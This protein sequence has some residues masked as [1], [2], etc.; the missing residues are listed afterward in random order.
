MKGQKCQRIIDFIIILVMMATVMILCQPIGRDWTEEE[1][2]RYIGAEG[3]YSADVDSYYY[4]RKAKEFSEGGIGSIKLITYRAEDKMCTSGEAISKEANGAMPMLL[5]ASAAL[6]WYGFRA[7]GINIGIYTLTIRFCSFLLSLFVIPVYLFLRRRTSRIA[8]VLGS[9][10]VTL[11]VPFFRH[12][13]AGFF[14]TDAM[15]G[16]LA[17]V[18][19]LSLF[20]C[21]VRKTRREQVIYGIVALLALVLLRFTWTAFFIY[22]VIA[23]GTAVMG[24]VG[25]RLCGKC[26]EKQKKSLAVPGAFWGAVI[27]I[28]LIL[29]WNSF[30]SLAKGFVSPSGAGD[31]PSETLNISELSKVPVSDAGSLWYHFVGVGRDITSVTGGIFALSLLLISAVICVVQLIRLIR[32]HSGENKDV[33]LL[34]ALLTWLAG[35]TVLAFFGARYMEFFTLPS[36]VIIGLK[37]D[38]IG[39]FCKERTPEGRKILYVLAGFMLFAA[40]VLRF[41]VAAVIAAVVVFVTGW[42]LARF[43]N[44]SVPAAVL[45]AAVLLPIGISCTVVC[46]QEKPYI[47]RPIEEAMTWVEKNTARDSVLADFW[48]LGYIYQY[49]GERRTLADGG[50]YNGQFF[51]WLAYMLTTEDPKLSVGIAGMLQNC[52][53]DGSEYAQELTGNAADARKL[54]KTVLPLSRSEA[55][56]ELKEK[57]AFSEAQ[58]TRLLDYTHP[59]ECPDI[60]FAVSRD[61]LAHISSLMV[62]KDWETG[63]TETA[64]ETYISTESVS[65]PNE[66]ETV[67]CTLAQGSDLSLQAV[68]ELKASEEGLT[69]RLVLPSGGR[70]DCG[71][72]L[73]IR[74]G[75]TVYD[76][77]V[78]SS[79]G[80]EQAEDEALMILEEGGKV[81]VIL[82]EKRAADSTFIKL[83]IGNGQNQDLFEKVY[84][85]AE[86]KGIQKRLGDNSSIA[87]W[88]VVTK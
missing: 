78:V 85:S 32:N 53:I 64:E 15:I 35:T 30:V 6:V 82:L 22:G 73:Y 2:E 10:L 63:D 72:L 50:T 4:L 81:S 45:A 26:D 1:A 16:L 61:T 54:L 65:R 74:D 34:S 66:G 18:L 12:S 83:F 7:V 44:E 75:E 62:Y 40:M 14:D 36:A 24:V 42:F 58:I 55:E 79:E 11:E 31:W 37:F 39:R 17:L 48:N 8:A 3:E 70:M 68:V 57:Y 77:M 86:G 25:I 69:G 84:D 59:A 28:S 51:Y 33:F 71:R 20:E 21:F 41:P 9:L 88:K 87:I 60:Y 80:E 13:H 38:S 67:L 43:N 56:T 27:V 5:P 52:G 23:A 76:R 19:V 46:A 49:Y 47:E 29:G